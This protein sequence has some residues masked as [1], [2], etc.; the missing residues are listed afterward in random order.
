VVVFSGSLNKKNMKKIIK[1]AG[2]AAG[3]F[4]C[5]L[6]PVLAGT[7]TVD[8]APELA[9]LSIIP[10]KSNQLV[11]PEDALKRIDG[12]TVVVDMTFT[13]ADSAPKIKIQ[14]N[15]LATS[16]VDA[17]SDYVDRYR[18]PCLKPGEAPVKLHQAYHFNPHD[19][20]PVMQPIYNDD[21]SL[22][23]DARIECMVNVNGA[24][25]PVFPQDVDTKREIQKYGLA[26][27]Y[28]QLTFTAPDQPPALEWIVAGNQKP[29]RSSITRYVAGLRMPCLNGTNFTTKYYNSFGIDQGARTFMKDRTL[30]QFVGMAAEFPTPVVFDLNTMACPFD[31]RV[32]YRQPY[33]RNVVLEYDKS[34]PGRAA[35]LEWLANVRLRLNE[36]DS[37]KVFM[38][39]FTLSIPCGSVTL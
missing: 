10:G 39:V 22:P 2:L 19:S 18:L 35:F 7:I 21:R 38:D 4:C 27:F 5:I 30:R 8:S 36:D 14:E 28:Y 3:L 25:G 32:T 31:L 37:V 16:L 26:K 34:V 13:A 15:Q 17:V 6:P 9:C 12:G 33:E 23:Y 1:L 20:R 29:L 24:K 11:Y